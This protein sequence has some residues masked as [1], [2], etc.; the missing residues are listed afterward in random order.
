MTLPLMPAALEL[1][2]AYDYAQA[3]TFLRLLDPSATKFTF[4]FF[5]DPENDTHPAVTPAGQQHATLKEVW[6]CII[7]QNSLQRAAGAFV[8]I[9]ETDLQGRKGANITRARALFADA[10][11]PDQVDRCADFIRARCLPSAI[12]QTRP[13]RAHF[14]WF[15][16]DL[17]LE[18]FTPLQK[19]LAT[20]LQTDAT[21]TD[22]PR[23]MRLP[24]TYNLKDPSHPH[25][26][27]LQFV[28]GQ[29][30]TTSEFVAKSGLSVGPR[31][32]AASARRVTPWGNPSGLS[33]VDLHGNSPRALNDELAAG[34]GD[35]WSIDDF[36]SAAMFLAERRPSPL[37]IYSDNKELGWLNFT[38][39]CCYG[40]ITRPERAE[41]I[42]SI[43]EGASKVAGGNVEQNET[44]YSHALRGTERRIVSGEKVITPPSVFDS[45]LRLGWFPK[46]PTAQAGGAAEPPGASGAG[47]ATG[48][49]APRGGG[50]AGGSAERSDK[51]DARQ[52]FGFSTETVEYVPG[53][54]HVCREALDR[55]VA[56]DPH[57]YKSGEGLIILRVPRR[58]ELPPGV[59]WDADFPS[60]TLAHPA[61]IIERAERIA[62]MSKS[63][64]KGSNRLRRVN[65]P[66]PFC[67]D[68]IIQMRGR[69]RARP[70]TGIARVPYMRDNGEIVAGEGYNALTG[71]FHDRALALDVPSSPTR[72]E[73]LRA[74]VKLL[75]PFAH[76]KFEDRR[77]GRN[78]VLAAVLTALVRSF[79]PTA[80]MFI[81][82][83]AMAGTGKGQI[84]RAIA[85]LALDS[86]PVFMTWGH[87]DEEFQKRLDTMLLASPA[88]LVIDNANGKLLRGDTLEMVISEGTATIRH[89]GKLEGAT[90][91]NRSFLMATG[92]NLSISGDMIR[93]AVVID[94]LPRSGSP[95]RDLFPFTP[96]DYVR[97][98]RTELLDAAYTLM[99]AYRLAGMPQPELP[100]AG[101]FPQWE[102]QVRD[103]VYWLL[104][105]D[106]TEQF[107]KNKIA[108]PH[109]QNDAALLAALHGKHG[110][111]PFKAADVEQ[112]VTTVQSAKKG[113][114]PAPST[115]ATAIHAAVEDVWGG[116]QFNSKSFGIWARGNE[117][118]FVDGFKLTAHRDRNKTNVYIVHRS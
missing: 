24:G 41:V 100:S 91:R 76:Y 57:T 27:R 90:V 99:R 49:T 86:T 35:Q 33:D 89:F 108:D 107:E 95:E 78:L 111:K 64:G 37:A 115:E 8:T 16:D 102:R 11:G 20:I 25:F 28:S 97:E 72:R 38:F 32:T 82:K 75:K 101:S 68:Y 56:A 1:Q 48:A 69:Y 59:K 96:E 65:P 88:M 4:Q 61:D 77:V 114:G 93:R 113:Y 31:S 109:R 79:L 84:A 23:V 44:I 74:T 63:G 54:E 2:L 94:V 21:V 5:K 83:G 51:D 117:N 98:H 58:E 106:L 13:D 46:G 110:S 71:V 112:D 19:A 104:G 60:T 116:R 3:E 30:W 9:N 62:W 105:Y 22:L 34:I 47:G 52:P 42:R 66:R 15:S 14:Y 85:R 50:G 118:A 7:R 92:N 26:V 43:W 12:V 29:R 55:I 40:E 6:P 36:A 80:P 53:N 103:L 10:D 73:A 87:N 17:R 45:A 81:V 39:A 70:L 67:S 18:D